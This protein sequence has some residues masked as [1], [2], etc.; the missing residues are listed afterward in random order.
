MIKEHKNIE[1]VIKHL[2]HENKY[3]TTKKQKYN[4]PKDFIYEDARELFLNAKIEDA[5]NFDVFNL[6]ILYSTI[7]KDQVSKT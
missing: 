4:I 5:N 2:E 7:T 3:N 1:A 6:N